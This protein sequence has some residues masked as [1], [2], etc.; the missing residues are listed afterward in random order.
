MALTEL[1][2]LIHKAVPWQG[3]DKYAQGDVLTLIDS[4]KFSEKIEIVFNSGMTVEVDNFDAL[5]DALAWDFGQSR[6]YPD[7]ELGRTNGSKKLKL[8]LTPVSRNWL[9]D[10]DLMVSTI[11]NMMTTYTL[12]G[13]WDEA[14]LMEYRTFGGLTAQPHDGAEGSG[15][16][17]PP[18]RYF[19]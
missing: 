8:V 3:W 7:L 17:Q 18:D 6:R 16:A 15:K 12:S 19:V 1:I 9:K 10:L 14:T 5:L 11:R 2:E 4:I 13:D